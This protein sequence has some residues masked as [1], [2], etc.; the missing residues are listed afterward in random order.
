MILVF[1]LEKEI[2]QF[3]LDDCHL[4]LIEKSG[5]LENTN[6]NELRQQMV[7]LD[8][9][10]ICDHLDKRFC[11][12]FSIFMGFGLSHDGSVVPEF[13]VRGNLDQKA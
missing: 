9:F 13:S 11:K 2:H 3:V 5:C 12:D 8:I 7:I 4:S 10:V 1:Q 6:L